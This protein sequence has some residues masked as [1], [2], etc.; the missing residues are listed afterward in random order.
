MSAIQQYLDDIKTAVY[1]EEVRGSIHDAIEQCYEDV[2]AAKTIA[3]D[4]VRD[5]ADTVANAK[6]DINNTRDAGVQA[7]NEAKTTAVQTVNQTK[8]IALDDIQDKIDDAT[9][10][11]DAV[12]Q[13]A[14]DAEAYAKGTRKGSAVPDTDPA[15]E[16]NAK[17]F[18]EQTSQNLIDSRAAKTAT[19]DAKDI[20]VEASDTAVQA[21]N[22]IDALIASKSDA[23]EKTVSGNIVTFDDA[24]PDTLLKKIKV[25]IEPVQAGTGDPSPDNV[26][27]ITGWT[28]V[29]VYRQAKNYFNVNNIISKYKGENGS[30]V[31]NETGTFR[32]FFTGVSGNSTA[33]SAYGLTKVPFLKA[34]T[35]VVSYG[36]SESNA[37]RIYK[38]NAETGAVSQLG[39]FNS[40]AKFTLATDSLITIR[41]VNSSA[42]VTFTDF[43]IVMDG[44]S[45]EFEPYQGDSYS[46]TFPSEA[47]DN[48]TVYGGT[49]TL[50]DDGTGEL[51]VNK[52]ITTIHEVSGSERLYGYCKVSSYNR[53]R[54]SIMC[55]ALTP[56]TGAVSDIAENSIICYW[57]SARNSQLLA[58]KINGKPNKES[59][60]EERIEQLNNELQALADAGN[61]LQVVLTSKEPIATY[62]LTAPQI[63]TLLGEN[64]IF[65]D[66]GD[67][68]VTYRQSAEVSIRDIAGEVT[69]EKLAEIEP[70]HPH[71]YTATLTADNWTDNKQTVEIE[72]IDADETKQIIEPIPANASLQAYTQSGVMAINQYA[73]QLEFSCNT[74]PTDNLTVYIVVTEV[75]SE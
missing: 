70:H 25:N 17:Y 51:V 32:D 26:R 22:D 9:E 8:T 52:V 16:N 39:N 53:Y 65:A 34:G 40:G 72:V 63:K 15:Y 73:G 45:T 61:P 7:V 20:A 55:N 35:Y 50:N 3:D 49:L 1:G 44:A 28:G 69:D 67:V 10:D 27:P 57:S 71:I 21:K 54:A 68:E 41:S 64:N 33:V 43:S 23:I 62:Q 48:G 38:V 46:V 58:I 74:V 11:L 37:V 2:T 42:S 66:T 5:M 4:S 59:T 36:V 56:Q 13:A 31:I 18:Y 24:I 60:Y 14:S 30:I 75:M 12:K 6:I 19:E 47:G 29:K